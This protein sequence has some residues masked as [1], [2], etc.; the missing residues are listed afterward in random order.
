MVHHRFI[1]IFGV[2]LPVRASAMDLP[3]DRR[4]MYVGPGHPMTGPPP[5]PPPP[6]Q[7]VQKPGP[8]SQYAISTSPV[9]KAALTV[10]ELEEGFLRKA[11]RRIPTLTVQTHVLPS[12]CT[13]LFDGQLF[14]PPFMGG[15][16]TLLEPG[17]LASSSKMSASPPSHREH[18]PLVDTVFSSERQSSRPFLNRAVGS[19]ASTGTG[20]FSSSGSE[21]SSP[22]SHLSSPGPRFS[23]FSSNAPYSPN[24]NGSARCEVFSR[25]AS[26]KVPAEEP[27]YPTESVG[28]ES[29]NTSA[30]EERL[31]D[32]ERL[33]IER[34]NALS[35]KL[36]VHGAHILK[37]T[38]V[39]PSFFDELPPDTRAEVI[40][41]Y[42]I[43]KLEA[44]SKSE[45]RLSDLQTHYGKAEVTVESKRSSASLL[46]TTGL[47]PYG[48][49]KTTP[50]S[51]VSVSNG[52]Q[53]L[54]TEHKSPS[55]TPSDCE[56]SRETRQS[57]GRAEEM[58]GA[59]R[60]LKKSLTAAVHKT[61]RKGSRASSTSGSE[62]SS[63]SDREAASSPRVRPC[64]LQNN[65]FFFCNSLL[66]SSQVCPK[67]CHVNFFQNHFKFAIFLSILG[68]T[69][70]IVDRDAIAQQTPV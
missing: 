60:I 30:Q 48:H 5:P 54:R 12:D 65:T 23:F 14:E 45:S 59:A 55:P 40:K 47:S 67:L 18:N 61:K 52:S 25:L 36:G 15:N 70:M 51:D 20:I 32:T 26:G 43:P 44:L 4:Q 50:S 24:R 57:K 64:K 35:F 21:Y 37:Y 62:V 53:L 11:D 33:G 27:L 58:S 31:Y 49:S 22:A 63:R 10:A 8:Q 34:L 38:G 6:P 42:V 39:D 3:Y 68:F 46:P 2:K 1:L 29:L 28:I 9:P 19:P 7:W 66:K 41:A 16:N 56:C 69:M 13:T 17:W